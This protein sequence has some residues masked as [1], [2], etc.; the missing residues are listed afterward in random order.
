M[1]LPN[2]PE[3]KLAIVGVSRD[4]FPIELTRTRLGKL[5]EACKAAGI[6]VYTCKTI[7]EN[8]KDAMAALAEV[9]DAG[10]NAAVIY[11][12]NFGPEGP[13]SIFAEQFGGPVMACAAAEETKTNLING[14]GDAYCGMLNASYNFALRNLPAYIP[15][16]PVGLPDEL[17]QEDRALRDSR[18]DRAG[19]AEPEDFRLRP[20]AA[21]LLRLQRADQAALRPGRRGDGE[22]RAGPATCSTRS[23]A[24]NDPDIAPIARD[25]AAEL[26]KGNTYPDLLPKLARFEVALTRFCRG[27]PRARAV[28]ASSPTSAGRRSRRPSDS[29]RATSTRR[30]ATRGMPVACEVDIYGALSEYLCHLA[31]DKPADAAGH[32][33]HRAGRHDRRRWTSRARAPRT[34]SWASTAAT[35]RAAA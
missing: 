9:D 25:M 32:Q 2:A 18:P 4:C 30:L 5:T 11:L 6:S 35:R 1:A 34:C 27:Q 12:G 7:I 23:I 19:R 15:Q 33:Q 10:C 16:M 24:E 8:E 14:R 28:S 3:V 20:A 17:A 13:L 31:S 22:Q 26:G 21:G 29:C